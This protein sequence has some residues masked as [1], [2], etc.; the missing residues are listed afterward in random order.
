MKVYKGSRL[1]LNPFEPQIVY[2]DDFHKFPIPT[3]KGVIFATDSILKAKIFA[4]FSGISNFSSSTTVDSDVITVRVDRKLK[5]Q[6]FE[7]KV[8]IYEFETENNDWKYLNQSG[9]WYST[10]EQI[11][12]NISEYTRGELYTEIT[13]STDIVLY[14]EEDNID[15]KAYCLL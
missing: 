4:V 7:E 9:E 1:Y 6:Y 14:E 3:P 12:L 15:R 8:Y 5:E 10:K 13:N 11:P 2:P